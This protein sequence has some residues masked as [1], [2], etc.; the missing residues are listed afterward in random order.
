[1]QNIKILHVG[2]VILSL[3]FNGCVFKSISGPVDLLAGDLRIN[4]NK[5]IKRI[6]I[7]CQGKDDG[8][9]PDLCKQILPLI[10]E[11]LVKAE[12]VVDDSGDSDLMIKLSVR[13]DCYPT[14]Y[15]LYAFGIFRTN[16]QY[17]PRACGNTIKVSFRMGTEEAQK[18]Y[19]VYEKMGSSKQP[20][21]VESSTLRAVLAIKEDIDWIWIRN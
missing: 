21:D 3:S 13:R 7:V 18:T 14:D 1:M 4:S 9:A 6:S 11:Q 8:N 10:R 15:D 19:G 16:Y 12:Y 20:S 5:P 2:I 17:G